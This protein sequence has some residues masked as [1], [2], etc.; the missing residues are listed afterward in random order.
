MS[1]SPEGSHPK[2]PVGPSAGRFDGKVGV[3]TGGAS[4][5]G[6]ATVR[7][8]VAE[9]AQ[10]VIGDIDQAGLDAVVEQLGDRVAALR[11]DVS[12][13]SDVKE[14]VGTAVER[15]GGLHIA[16]ANAGV[17]AL[18]R[19]ID[20]RPHDW[21]RV[22]E[23]NV[24]GPVLMIKHAA[25][26]MSEGGSIVITASLNAVQPAAGMSAYCCSKAAASML[27]QVGAMELGSRGIRVNAVGPGLVRTALTEAA[28]QLPGMAEDFLENQPLSDPIT[29]DDI[30]ATVAFLASD[31]ARAVTGTL[32]LVDGG[33]RTKRYPD[34][35]SHLGM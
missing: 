17:A 18:G 6:L 27:A 19:L 2:G 23:V 35:L 21:M 13:E 16:F 26:V 4:G 7:R 25:P 11:C 31:D 9:G 8:F 3:V 24:L 32:Q 20:V 12:V 10:V 15:F 29:S 28:W 5:I 34:M 33:A 22:I 1:D 30:A 14:L